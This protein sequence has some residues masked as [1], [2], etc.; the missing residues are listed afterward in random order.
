VALVAVNDKQHM[1]TH[2]AAFCMLD[3][4]LQPGETMLTYCPAIVTDT[5]TPAF[6]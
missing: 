5:D 3:E 4:V 2:P 1:T 6:W